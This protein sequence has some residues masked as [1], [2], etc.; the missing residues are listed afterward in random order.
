MD[1]F[2]FRI[3]LV[4]RWLGMSW[5]SRWMGEPQWIY[6]VEGVMVGL[7][8]PVR[9][10]I[11][12]G[13][14]LEWIWRDW[15]GPGVDMAGLDWPWSGSGVDM[16]GLDWPLVS[17]NGIDTLLEVKRTNPWPELG[18]GAHGVKHGLR[19]AQP[20]INASSLKEKF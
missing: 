10:W 5:A 1:L 15:I 14:D 7:D 16:A 9:D 3:V 12:P 6:V 18:I 2:N 8:W 19:F 20:W 13:V 4:D 11:G 17:N